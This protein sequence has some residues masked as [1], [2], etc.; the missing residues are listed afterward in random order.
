[1]ASAQRL[2][3]GPLRR[4]RHRAADR[5]PLDASSPVLIAGQMPEDAS[6]G[7]DEAGLQRW[8]KASIAIMRSLGRAVIYRPHPEDHSGYIPDADEIDTGDIDE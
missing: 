6:H 3:D 1:M 2:S 8:T 5:A 7:L 4:A